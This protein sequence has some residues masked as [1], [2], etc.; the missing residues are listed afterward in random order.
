VIAG[1][2]PGAIVVAAFGGI[3]AQRDVE[4]IVVHRMN[5]CQW[6][7]RRRRS[8]GGRI[9]DQSAWQVQ[10]ECAAHAR[11]AFERQL[12]LQQASELPADGQPQSGAAVAA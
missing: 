8:L 5:R 3:V 11:R 10:R 6:R 9:F 12:P 7:C 1:R 4:Q 2:Q